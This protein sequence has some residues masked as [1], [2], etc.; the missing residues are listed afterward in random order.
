MQTDP[1]PA[2]FY[3]CPKKNRLNLI[4]YGSARHFDD[5]FVKHYFEIVDGSFTNEKDR[6]HQAS[7]AI[8]FLTGEENKDMLSA[9]YNAA[10]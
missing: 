1:N 3:Y 9:H 7:L 8:G 10:L 4:D 6:I 5:H 2:N